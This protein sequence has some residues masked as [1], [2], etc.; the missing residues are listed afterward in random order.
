MVITTITPTQHITTTKSFYVLNISSM[1]LPFSFITATFLDLG[2][3]DTH[4]LLYLHQSYF[5]TT[6][7]TM[8]LPFP[9]SSSGKNPLFL[10]YRPSLVYKI[11]HGLKSMSSQTVHFHLYASTI[12]SGSYNM[13]HYSALFASL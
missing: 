2:P 13:P 5:Q 8:P 1:Y 6:K 10:G 4:L 11:L 7:L 3:L 12:R 9:F